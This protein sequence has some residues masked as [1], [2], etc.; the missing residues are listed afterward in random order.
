MDMNSLLQ[1]GVKAFMNSQGSGDAGSNLDPG[2]LGSA[3]SGLIGNGSNLDIASL[4]GNMQGGGM[5]GLLSSWM[6]DGANDAASG[7]QITDMLGD[8]KVSAFASQLGLSTE[9]A[10]GGL[11]DAIPPMVDKASSGGS[12]LDALGGASGALG[13]ASKLFS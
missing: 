6:G 1:L 13:M 3:L 8:D 4:I 2:A 12:L 11:Q 5:A 9:Q 10:V 7:S